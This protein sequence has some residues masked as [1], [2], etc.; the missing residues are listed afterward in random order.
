VNCHPEDAVK[1]I[2]GWICHPEAAGGAEPKAKT[3]Q[4]AEGSQD[5]RLVLKPGF[6]WFRVTCDPSA[7]S[8]MLAF[9]SPAPAAS[10]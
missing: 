3:P 1:K 6:I 2:R 7:T 4:D 5:A 9:G 8:A 10:G